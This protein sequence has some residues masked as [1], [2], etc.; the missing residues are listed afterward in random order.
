M[1]IEP[2]HDFSKSDWKEKYTRAPKKK[3]N[4][5][6][7]SSGP[8]RSNFSNHKGSFSGNKTWSVSVMASVVSG[9]K[10][11]GRAAAFA[12]YVERPS[13]CICSIGDKDAKEKFNELEK[14]LLSQ[15]PRRVTQRRLIIPVPSEFLKNADKNMQKFADEFGKKY[16]DICST[17]NMALHSG[18]KDLKNPHI[19]VI[20]SPTDANGKNI[21]DL[22]KS[23]YMFLDSFKKDVGKFIERELNIKCNIGLSKKKKELKIKGGKHYKKW[24]IAA[25]KKYSNDPEKLKK[26]AEKYKDL[27]DYIDNLKANEKIKN[28]NELEK[29][30]DKIK[31]EIYD[32]S[33]KNEKTFEKITGEEEKQFLH[34]IKEIKNN[35]IKE[36]MNDMDLEPL[37]NIDVVELAE[38][39]G[40]ERDKYDRKAYRRG[41][42][43]ISI[44]ERTGRFN[45]FID[46]NVHGRGAIDFIIKTENKDFKGAIEFLSNEY[47]TTTAT[48]PKPN[49]SFQRENI[50]QAQAKQEEPEKIEPEKKILELPTKAENTEK[51]KAY[52]VG[53]R[54][55]SEK[56]VDKLISGNMIYQDVKGNVVFL[57]RDLTGKEI[58]GAELKNENFKGLVKG[59]NRNNGSF[60]IRTI[61]EGDK[62]LVI[63]ESAIDAISYFG[64][65]K[66]L[67]TAIVSTSGVM[68]H[69]TKFVD[70]YISK[71]NVKTVKIAYD[72]DVAGITNAEAL[73]ADIEK[74]YPDIQIEIERSKKKDWNEDLQELQ[75]IEKM[76]TQE[77]QAK[78]Q[79]KVNSP[80]PSPFIN[81]NNENKLGR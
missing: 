74:K 81:Q 70:D 46:Q 17:W 43:K 26:Y 10:D 12:S 51:L 7:I 11:K 50:Q 39:M 38:R 36:V 71:N 13:E 67:N 68:P 5:L 75:E 73:K 69:M 79:K 47:S 28:I 19:H 14:K 24:I 54:K 16:F 52:L 20:F 6:R 21:R 77:L 30:H 33:K 18:G 76:Q 27:A 44:D 66:P 2:K 80:S 34:K 64:L 29:K 9:V 22:S 41:D 40:F 8:A 72:N 3:E 55:I 61:G 15:N 57:S 42:M 4:E 63:T 35:A 62:K 31:K 23:N 48:K 60:Q 37:K 59:S 78:Q 1:K 25:Y 49:F 45:S 56:I 58:T 32:F 53:K 65:K